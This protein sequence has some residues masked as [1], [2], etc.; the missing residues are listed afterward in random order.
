MRKWINCTRFCVTA[1][2]STAL[3][4][5]N[6][7]QIPVFSCKKQGAKLYFSVKNE[8]CKKVFAIFER[9]C[10]NII[11]IKQLGVKAALQKV[12][13]RMGA[14]VG[15]LVFLAVVLFA[16]HLVLKISVQGSG[17]YLQPQIRRIV[18]ELGVREG[19]PFP[20][21][22]QKQA[23]AQVMALPNVTFCSVQKRGSILYINVQ[24]VGEDTNPAPVKGL[25]A[26]RVGTV[27]AVQAQSGTPLVAVGQQVQPNTPLIGAYLAVNEQNIPTLAVGFCTL[28]C[29]GEVTYFAT[30]Q[31]EQAQRQAYAACLLYAAQIV[32]RSH[33]VR[34]V[35][36]GVNYVVTFTYH[37]TLSI[38]LP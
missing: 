34:T 9:P 17:S 6:R 22:A 10:Y 37:H 19:A 3:N 14:W 8:Y 1:P 20:Q 4:K 31:T 16:N 30:E 15:C 21:S 2:L 5:L 33:T 26:D 11:V 35:E 18:R 38:N 27:I 25:F 32:E 28:A 24:T 29:V 13:F 23:I 7:E 36:G 12:F